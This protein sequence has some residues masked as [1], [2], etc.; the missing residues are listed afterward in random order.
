MKLALKAAI[1]IS[2]LACAVLLSFNWSEQCGVSL[3]V[4]TAQANG[5][6]Y[7]SSYVAGR[8]APAPRYYS[9]YGP[10]VYFYC[11]YGTY[12]GYGTLR[13]YYRSFAIPGFP[14][15]FYAAW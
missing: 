3:G 9:P 8:P 6:I 2:T 5:R 15:S 7:K 14:A 1:A 12:C 11:S 4:E 10:G 13:D